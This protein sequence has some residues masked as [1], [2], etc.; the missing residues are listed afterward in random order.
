MPARLIS[1]MFLVLHLR[2]ENVSATDNHL[3][4]DDDR[5]VHV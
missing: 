2:I 4:N 5:N 3:Y 1:D